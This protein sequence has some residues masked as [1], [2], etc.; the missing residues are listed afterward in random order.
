MQKRKRPAGLSRRSEGDFFKM[1]F[2]F[3]SS[4]RG[5]PESAVILQFPPRGR[6]GVCVK[7]EHDGLDTWIALAD[8]IRKIASE[9]NLTIWSSAETFAP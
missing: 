6:L 3:P 7:R 5:K 4:G 9:L 1:G 2:L 8:P